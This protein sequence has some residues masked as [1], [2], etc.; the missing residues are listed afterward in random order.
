MRVE[1]QWE[2][3]II[4]PEEKLQPLADR[5]YFQKALK[6]PA[7]QYYFSEAKLNRELGHIVSLPSPIIRAVVPVFTSDAQIFGALVININFERLTNFL[8]EHPTN[9][10]YLIANH[11][12]D[13][14]FHPDNSKRFAFEFGKRAN[15]Q[16]DFPR[17]NFFSES[18]Y[19]SK[20]TMTCSQSINLPEQNLYL[21]TFI[22]P[23][24]IQIYFSYSVLLPLTRELMPSR[25]NSVVVCF[26]FLSVS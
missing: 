3:I 13:Y 24:S 15:I 4:V 25:C 10:H 23:P 18:L 16:D 17:L 5:T 2:N 9:I 1:R 14:L 12:G 8:R 11:N 22:T 19:F 21:T 20:G 26:S 7:G 6:L